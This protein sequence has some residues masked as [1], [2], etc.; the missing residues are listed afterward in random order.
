MNEC[1][2]YN[3]FKSLLVIFY[4]MYRQ[5]LITLYLPLSDDDDSRLL[6]E[7]PLFTS[8]L[9]LLLAFAI[10]HGYFTLEFRV[11]FME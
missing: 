5:L 10:Y 6:D 7:L 4:Y 9:L 1:T 2:K 8:L 11:R 3:K